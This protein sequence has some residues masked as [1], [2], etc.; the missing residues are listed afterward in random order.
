MSQRVYLINEKVMGEAV[1]F[2]AYG[3]VVKYISE[4]SEHE[5]LVESDEILYLDEMRN[6]N[7]M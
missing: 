4:G 7:A 6:I 5:V 1:K 3:A 2:L